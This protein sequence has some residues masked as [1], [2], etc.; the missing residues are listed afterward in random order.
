LPIA[1]QRRHRH[2]QITINP[3]GSEALVVYRKAMELAPEV[4][5]FQFW[6]AA[7]L[8]V[9][10]KESEATPLFR[11][12]FSKEPFWLEV[13]RRL[14]AADLFPSE[15]GMMMRMEALAPTP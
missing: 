8:V 11:D 6:Y 12:L 7:T 14:P 13:L 2:N 1:D 5:E 10:D 3:S 4:L 15:P 9:V